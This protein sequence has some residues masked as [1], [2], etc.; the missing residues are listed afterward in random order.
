MTHLRRGNST[1]RL[2]RF[3]VVAACV[4]V[5]AVAGVA[6]P[7]KAD[8]V[9]LVTNG[10]FADTTAYYTYNGVQVGTETTNTNLAAWQFTG[11]N[12]SNCGFSFLGNSNLAS[13]GFY[14]QQDGHISTEGA[15][16]GALPVAGSNAFMSDAN[17]ATQY[18]FQSIA[19]LTAGD[20]YTLKFWQASFEQSGYTGGF[21]SNWQVG[22]GNGNAFTTANYGVQ[23]AAT[24]TVPSG[25]ASAWTQQTLSFVANSTNEL[26]AFFATASSGAQPPF[27]MLDGV[28]L[29]DATHPVNVPE[30]ATL[31]LTAAGVLGLVAARRRRRAA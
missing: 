21:T 27:L 8:L 17:Y 22:L 10:N 2:A 23:T 14:D 25:G 19:G 28:S 3:H 12:S 29:T 1:F 30:P 9:N 5:A 6:S 15:S 4:A 11:C 13:T 20:T 7:A 24:M 16:P 18:M 31:G 26:L